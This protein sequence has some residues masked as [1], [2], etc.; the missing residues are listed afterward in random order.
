MAASV[1]DDLE[2]RTCVA[3]PGPKIRL[4]FKGERTVV[5]VT[6]GYLASWRSRSST[7][8]RFGKRPRAP[9]DGRL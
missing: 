3:G 5:V 4:H 7:H 9:L 8:G 1:K 2:P 6:C